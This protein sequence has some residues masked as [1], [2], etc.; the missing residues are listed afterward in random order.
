MVVKRNEVVWHVSG[1]LIG[2]VCSWRYVM[3]SAENLFAGLGDWL[4]LLATGAGA[5]YVAVY[6]LAPRL[7]RRTD[8]LP[9]R[10]FWLLIRATAALLL[11][12]MAV[13]W[14]LGSLTFNLGEGR[15][16]GAGIRN[17][18]EVTFVVVLTLG[19]GLL[20]YGHRW[21]FIQYT[22][23][24]RLQVRLHRYQRRVASLE[25]VWLQLELPPHL[26]FNS[27]AT[28]RQLVRE[29]SPAAVEAMSLL[30]GLMRFYIVHRQCTAIP[31]NL[32]LQ[33]VRTLLALYAIR[34]GR[35]VALDI[36]AP[37]NAD[38]ITILPM[39][40]LL[41]TENMVRHGDLTGSS[42]RASL[43]IRCSANRVDI[44]AGNLIAV[45]RPDP[46]VGLGIAL[47]NLRARLNRGYPGHAGF[48][49]RREGNRFTVR[50]YYVY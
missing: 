26:L 38:G 44:V 41:L 45:R 30:I 33:Q 15:H 2:A 17:L 1:W 22:Y 49:T 23:R 9:R 21:G 43:T 47:D 42:G 50:A 32:E 37:D 48:D 29:R 4:T 19:L 13:S 12:L 8:Q 25:Q 34:L 7:F 11:V 18:P 16:G 28:V 40:L 20:V 39:L 5:F 10:A 46:Q 14:W 24:M 27:L 3:V 35:P 36:R 31:L 6:G